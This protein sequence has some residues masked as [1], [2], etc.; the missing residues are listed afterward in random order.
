MSKDCVL[1]IEQLENK[2][3][4]A[5]VV[6]AIVDS[7]ID[8]NHSYLKDNLWTNPYE[9][10]DGKDNDN[11]GYVDDING[12]DFVN[13]DNVP[14]DS[15]YHGTAVAGVVK[16][17]DPNVKLMSLRF[18]DSNGLGYTGAAASAINYATNM[19]LKGINIASI[20]L[21]WGGGTSSSLILESAIK[22]ANDA[23]IIVVSA[24]G[25]N[26]DNNDVTP[27][28]PSSY[29]FSNTISV[30][31]YD[32]VGLASFS[33]YGKN[34]VEVAS[35]AVGVYSSLPNNNYGYLSGTSFASPYVAG[36]ASTLRRLGNYSAGQIK[37]AI[38][39]GCDMVQSIV[40]RVSHGLVN[41]GRSVSYILSLSPGGSVVVDPPVVV[42]SP[43]LY[44]VDKVSKSLI[45]GWAT[46]SGNTAN[47]LKVEIKINN[48][49]GYS[50]W[51]SGLRSDN[52]SGSGFSVNLK[53]FFSLRKNRV[54]VRFIDTI[55][56]RV[57]LG[58]SGIIKK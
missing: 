34:S 43:I 35:G 44:H 16:S 13:N 52:H 21:S 2:R 27:R 57:V 29:K 54:E 56:N 4:L 39:V 11:N 40:D 55:N 8:L 49:L 15:F 25:N 7:G 45:S 33:N 46:D 24:A 50:G 36:M 58:Y 51:A 6:V 1:S 28:Y 9:I 30:A 12:W 20:N 53:R 22:R 38:L 14:E 17:A 10:M 26:G 32:G 31:G 37:R 5:N 42:L 23:G 18:Q 3:V 47:K 19:K 41:L 48:R